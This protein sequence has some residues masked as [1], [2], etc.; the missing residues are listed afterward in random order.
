VGA[1]GKEEEELRNKKQ[2]R[3]LMLSLCDGLPQDPY[4][5]NILFELIYHFS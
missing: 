2:N 1:I 5:G 4:V 3:F